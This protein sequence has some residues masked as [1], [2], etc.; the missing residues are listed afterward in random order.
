MENNS[1]LDL[2]YGITSKT[3]FR[4]STEINLKV[5]SETGAE[6]LSIMG[7][8]RKKLAD[9]LVAMDRRIAQI[10]EQLEPG[11]N[12]SKTNS[13]G[14]KKGKNL[15]PVIDLLKIHPE[16]QT[17][18]QI[19]DATNI[20]VSSVHLVTKDEEQFRVQDGKVFLKS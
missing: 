18:K 1:T 17:R 11:A 3:F 12:R 16:G 4:M 14:R 20:G 19:A 5:D 2:I 9:E 6:I 13:R 8:K 10:K 15:Q 7:Q